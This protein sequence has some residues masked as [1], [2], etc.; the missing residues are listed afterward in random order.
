M[1]YVCQCC[2][3]RFD[4][5]PLDFVGEAPWRNMGVSDDEFDARVLLEKSLCVVDGQFFFVRGHIRLP[6]LGTD[7]VF[8]WSVWCSLSND[9][10]RHLYEHWDD[11]DRAGDTYFGWLCTVL[12]CYEA[13]TWN[14][15]SNVRSRN[16]DLVPLIEIQPV[17]HPIYQEQ[18]EGITVERWHSIAHQLLHGR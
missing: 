10:F 9:S 5:L 7:D 2:G 6:I 18:Q 17:D 13:T 1:S 16:N 15:K 3:Q 12:P 4:G 14:L 8:V 11:S